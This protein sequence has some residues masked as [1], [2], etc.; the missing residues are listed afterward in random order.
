[1]LAQKIGGLEQL[2]LHPDGQRGAERLEAARRKGEVSLEQPLELE[3]RL[4]V[5]G[6]EVDLGGARAAR[7]EA[8]TDRVVRE[9][10]VV[11]LAGE[12]L[13]LRGGGHLPLDE[14]RRRGVVVVRRDAE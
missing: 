8:G 5:E 2:I 10:R 3:E 11:L 14:Q 13:F 12:A 4:V 1:Q 6:D 7:F 9:A